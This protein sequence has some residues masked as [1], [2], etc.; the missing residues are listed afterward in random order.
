MS[1]LERVFYFHQEVTAGNYPNSRTIS[2]HFEVS[3]P[4][5]RRD[6]NYLR[7]RL[8][9]PLEFDS[10]KNGFYYRHENFT[11]PFEDSPRIVFLLAML[12]KLAGEAGLA[13]LQEVQQLEKKLNTLISADYN[14]F[15]DTLMVEWIEVESVQHHI[16]EAIT[17][18]V[19]NK[20]QLDLV[21]QS[22]GGNK[23]TRSIDP[24]K[25]INYQG[26][27][28]LFGYCNLRKDYRLF[29]MG[30]IERAKVMEESAKREFT[31]TSES[32]SE[33]F[34]I[35]QG[36]PRYSAEILFSG[37]AAQLVA[38]QH[39]HKNQKLQRVAE[40]VILNLPVSDDREII[41]K[42]LQYGEMARVISPPELTEK[43]KKKI[44]AMRSIYRQNPVP[45]T[46]RNS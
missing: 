10:R 28:Y 17:E 35:F 37:T 2:D 12:G 43:I 19:V 8:L 31:P 26:R 23:T 42:I 24:F 33:S 11:L 18:A 13:K 21:Y 29:H 30:R 40:G 15:V 4:T 20:R 34:G 46:Q 38:K 32:L 36:A 41:M 27:W 14:Q 9:A 7:D 22:V 39:W 16:F 5:A 44:E 45:S 1:L 6:I 3:I 25:I